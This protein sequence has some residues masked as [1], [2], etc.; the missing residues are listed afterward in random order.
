M[1]PYQVFQAN[2]LFVV[3]AII[4]PTICYIVGYYLVCVTPALPINFKSSPKNL[5]RINT[6]AYLVQTSAT[7]KVLFMQL[8][9]VW[10]SGC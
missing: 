7:K 6:R 2:L 4:L 1:R 8:H 5:T 3:K 10:N 9:P